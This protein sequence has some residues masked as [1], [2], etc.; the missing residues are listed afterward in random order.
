V[1]FPGMAILLLVLG[2]NLLQ[3]GLRLALDPR[4]TDR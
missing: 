2:L 4:L 1:I 3:E